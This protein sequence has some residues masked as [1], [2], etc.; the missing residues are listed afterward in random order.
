MEELA[1]MT[2]EE[3]TF[4]S[5]AIQEEIAA[6]ELLANAQN[7]AISLSTNYQEAKSRELA[8]GEHLVWVR[9]TGAH[10]A[11]DLG[12]VVTHNDSLWESKIHA[13]VWEPSAEN[14]QWWD[15]LSAPPAPGEWNGNGHTYLTGDIVTYQGNTYK[16]ITGHTSQPGWTPVAVPALWELQP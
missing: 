5:N 3:L 15:N 10:N 2:M 14:W 9:P 8:E 16:C 6:R 4:L 1:N 11:Y 12:R 7:I 13:N